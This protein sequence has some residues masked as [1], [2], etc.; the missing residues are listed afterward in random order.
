[1]KVKETINKYDWLTA[2]GCV[3]QAWFALRAVPEPPNEAARFRME[4]GQEIGALARQ[5][6]PDGILVGKTADQ[7]VEQVT[8]QSIA[9]PG[10]HT[11]FEAAFR[12]GRLV[13]KAD[14]LRRGHDGWHVLEVKSS[15]AE[16]TKSKM[17]SLV[18]DLAYT[19]MVLRQSGLQVSKAS[20]VL[21]SRSFRFGNAT[22]QLFEIID[23]TAEVNDRVSEMNLVAASITEAVFGNEPPDPVLSSTCRDC[24]FFDSQCLG[25]GVAHTVFEIPG[26]HHT[27][28]K[29]L[30]DKGIVDLAKLPHDL[31]LKDTQER[32]KYSILSGSTIV[33]PG[34]IK[35][36]Q[37]IEWPCRYL[38]FETVATALPMFAQHGCH[39]QILTQFSIHHLDDLNGDLS[40]SEFL[41]DAAVDGQ[42]ELAEALIDQ[43]GTTGSI[44]VYSSFE[45]TRIKALGKAFSDLAPKIEQIQARL[46]DLL[47]LIQNHVYHPRFG[48]RFSIKKV[49]P[50]LVPELSYSGLA[51]ANGDTAITRFARMARGEISGADVAVT[52]DQLLEY[53]KMDTLAMVRLHQ[54]L[55]DLAADRLVAGGG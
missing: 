7:A 3:T 48:G 8:H 11:L 47:P 40:H 51:V 20:L 9:D 21:L 41:A 6:Y 39:Q 33:E 17:R 35:L 45:K 50:A 37:A 1:M 14:I 34:L 54:A 4:Q 55:N 25:A 31:E 32:A 18:D 19:V 38:D 42:R 49:L 36:L 53:C 27:K 16:A 26:L 5:L 23:Q 24:D 52:R 22:D 28:L 10:V 44:L 13:A 12:A 2:Q 29:I 43:L 46:I 15:F 30:A